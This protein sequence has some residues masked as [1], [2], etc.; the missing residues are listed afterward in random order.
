VFGFHRVVLNDVTP[1]AL[2]LDLM[3]LHSWTICNRWRTARRAAP[4]RTA[5]WPKHYVAR[6]CSRSGPAGAVGQ[7]HVI[8]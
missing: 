5:R 8:V 6:R 7:R 3:C 4:R 2:I 1:V